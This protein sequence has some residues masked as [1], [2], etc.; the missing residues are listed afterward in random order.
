MSMRLFTCIVVAASLAP[1]AVL[2]EHNASDPGKSSTTHNS[3][4]VLNPQKLPARIKNKL[5]QDGFTDVRVIPGSFL[6]SA[7]DKN[8]DNVNMIIGPN[9]MTM[10]TQAPANTNATNGSGTGNNASNE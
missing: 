4:A 3:S 7:K 2:A 1:G 9:S 5:Q 6:G 8:G 10:L